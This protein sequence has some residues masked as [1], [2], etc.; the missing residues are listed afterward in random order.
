M[1]DTIE[2][3]DYEFNDEGNEAEVFINLFLFVGTSTPLGAVGLE[4]LET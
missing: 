1:K 3:E 4:W 2:V